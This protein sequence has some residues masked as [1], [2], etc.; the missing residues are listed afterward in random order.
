VLEAKLM[1]AT[2]G[3]E[4]V[5][6]AQQA[7]S[8]RLAVPLIMAAFTVSEEQAAAILDSQFRIATTASREQIQEEIRTL[9]A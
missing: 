3:Q 1:A 7:A 6:I 9:R 2:R 4:V 8:A 5:A